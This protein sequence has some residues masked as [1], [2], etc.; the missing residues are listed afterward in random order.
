MLSTSVALVAKVIQV[1]CSSDKYFCLVRSGIF[2]C[3]GYFFQCLGIFS[4]CNLGK[5]IKENSF[6]I[7]SPK[8]LPGTDMVLPF[9]ILGDE[10]FPL[11]TNLM[12]PYPRNQSL[13]DRSKAVFNYRLFRARRIVENAFGILTNRFRVFATPI[14]VSTSSIENAVTAACII[15]NL[16]IDEKTI[17]ETASNSSITSNLESVYDFE[18]N[19]T[20]SIE[21]QE[22]RDKFRNYFNSVGSIAWQDETF[23]L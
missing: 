16:M 4:K 19:E 1:M 18:G 8:E 11:L 21:P 6:D 10:A 3:F 22:I 7:P 14:H 13:I 17:S 9:V 15:H 12:K 23:R 20:T 2:H 5:A